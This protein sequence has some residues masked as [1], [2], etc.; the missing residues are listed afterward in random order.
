M[1]TGGQLNSLS[2][3]AGAFSPTACDFEPN[4]WLNR[5]PIDG[6]GLDEAPDMLPQPD[7]RAPATVSASAARGRAALSAPIFCIISLLRIPKSPTTR[8]LGAGAAKPA[9]ARYNSAMAANPRRPSQCEN[10]G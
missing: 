3:A 6:L 2:T 5:S 9:P 7:K 10:K 1:L 4:N 8:A